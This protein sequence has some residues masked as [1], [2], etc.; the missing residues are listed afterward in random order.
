MIF[1]K[2]QIYHVL[3]QGNKREKIFF[4]GNNYLFFL[5]KIKIHISP[6]AD[7]LAWCLMPNHFHLMIYVNEVEI[8]SQSS[9][10]LNANK[11]S[12]KEDDSAVKYSTLNKSIGTMLS[13][14]TRAVNIEKNLS[15]SIFRQKT[16]A[17]CLT[18]IDKITKAWYISQGATS[19]NIQL[20]E[21]Q[22]PN[23]CYNYILKNPVKSGLVAR[24]ADWE[25]TSYLDIA[26]KRKGKLLAYE[27]IKDLG[28]VLLEDDC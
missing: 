14:Y 8:P 22:Y 7:I 20:P 2:E 12:K 5:K 6:F 21:K 10:T 24:Y 11:I 1:E 28:L 25:F 17:L 15:G 18:R 9:S 23:V 19:I 3:N 16:K 13:S 26:G 4:S 27:R